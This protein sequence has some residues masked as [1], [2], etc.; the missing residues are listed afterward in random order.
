MPIPSLEQ[1]PAA[2]IKAFQESKLQGLLR[3]LAAHSPFYQD[4][5]ARAGVRIED[6][7]QLED[8]GKLPVT[9]KHD[10]HARHADFLCVDPRRIIDYVCT[11]G[12]QGQPV[13]FGLTEQ[14]LNRLAYNEY[15]SL[16]CA[17]GSADELYQL[18][19]TIDK[20]FMAGMAYF[21]GARQLGAGIIRVGSG[22]VEMQ[23]DTIQ[24]LR[25]TAL[26]AV[27]SFVLKLLEY[28][29]DHHLDPAA[30][31]VRKIICIGENIRQADFSLNTLGQR[32][33]AAWDVEL[34]STYASTEMGTS[35]TECAAGQGGHQHPELLIVEVLDQHNQP[36]P[37]GAVGELTIT[38]LGVEGMPLLRF[39]TGDLCAAHRSPCACGR[40]TTRLSP[41][42]GRKQQMLKYKGTTLYPQLIHDALNEVP[43]VKNYVVESYTNAIGTDEVLIHVGCHE[44]PGPAQAHLLEHLRSKLR[45]APALL[46]KSVAEINRMQ[47]VGSTR[48]PILFIDRRA[49]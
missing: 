1:Q 16:A 49:A 18:T 23:W 29:A 26:I 44:L 2:T 13:T 7:T 46:I 27:P 31:S 5:F 22:V 10:L 38:T 34:Y 47:L 43:F 24:R 35:F 42:V 6:I 45:V 15:L 12:T 39:K 25:P 33:R 3:Y 48:K 41:I 28:A 14:D 4:A 20:R 32:I 21:L 9:T 11:S 37:E 30:S 19:T 36:V 40:T 8:L 17:G